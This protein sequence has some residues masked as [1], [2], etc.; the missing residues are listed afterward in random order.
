MDPCVLIS[1]VSSVRAA[2][3]QTQVNA[4]VVVL[5]GGFKRIISFQMEGQ[6]EEGRKGLQADRQAAFW[7][8]RRQAWVA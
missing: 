6:M 4:M 5:I 8:A 7:K 2:S 1:L 3:L